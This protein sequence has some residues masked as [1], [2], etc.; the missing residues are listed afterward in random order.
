MAKR[1]VRGMEKLSS[2]LYIKQ[3]NRVLVGASGAETFAG[4]KVIPPYVMPVEYWLNL[5]V[6]ADG[7]GLAPAESQ[8]LSYRAGLVEMNLNQE[9]VETDDVTGHELIGRYMHPE[10]NRFEDTSDANETGLGIPHDQ[11]RRS[12]WW[13]ARELLWYRTRLGLPDK[14]VFTDANLILYVDKFR[15]HAKIKSPVPIDQP[16]LF[17]VGATMDSIDVETDFGDILWGG[18]LET[19]D[20]LTLIYDELGEVQAGGKIGDQA[21]HGS[22][23]QEWL[24]SGFVTA[25]LAEQ[26]CWIETKLTIRC[27]VFKVANTKQLSPF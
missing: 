2:S 24:E 4:G 10:M 11:Q 15:K 7:A 6:V 12:S 8:W 18:S 16:K 25:A 21:V 13:K 1:S 23:L 3:Y 19:G 27:E 5:N 20:L 14:A 26:N 17:G 22:T 9:Q